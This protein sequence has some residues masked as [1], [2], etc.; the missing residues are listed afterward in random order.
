M[1]LLAG[2][3]ATPVRELPGKA[4]ERTDRGAGFEALRVPWFDE[5]GLTLALDAGLALPGEALERAERVVLALASPHEQA[6]LARRALGLDAPLVQ[7]SGPLA[8]LAALE[9]AG[10]EPTLVLAG[11]T[12]EGGAGV[13]VLLAEGEGVPV[14]AVAEA[15]GAPLGGDAG[16][17]V[18]EAVDALGTE[19]GPLRVAAGDPGRVGFEAAKARTGTIGDA[20][21]A[22]PL[23]ELVDALGSEGGPVRVAASG[24]DQGLAL[25]FGEGAIEAVWTPRRT[26]P[27]EPA[28]LERL[29]SADPVPWSEAAQ[30]AYVSR[31]EYD[32]EPERRYGARGIGPGEVT[33]A[34]TIQAGPPGEFQRQ[35]EAGGPYD[36]VIVELDAGGRRIAQSAL[37]PGVL[38]IGDRVRP[39][40]RRLFSMEGTWRYAVKF[41]HEEQRG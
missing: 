37:P 33:A 39:V 24:G 8:G 4:L 11:G 6:S 41:V 30:G 20:G 38:G 23:V 12:G 34:T 28:A 1:G 29:E 40:L 16:R 5:D 19:Q 21:P 15:D 13:A 2:A 9:A 36:V 10:P 25:A 18:S 3:V 22:G 35:H 7:A 26:H 27:V 32:A 31:E 17:R 14:D